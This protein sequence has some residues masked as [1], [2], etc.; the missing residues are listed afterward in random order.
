[1]RV[2]CTLGFVEKIYQKWQKEHT[3]LHM[4]PQKTEIVEIEEIGTNVA[5]GERLMPNLFIFK[6]CT[7]LILITG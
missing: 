2:M 1:M 4:I 5:H 7:A 6:L 3:L